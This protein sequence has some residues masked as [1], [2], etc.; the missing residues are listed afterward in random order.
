MPGSSDVELIG[1]G[2]PSRL[3]ARGGRRGGRRGRRRDE[4]LH[5]GRST[6]RSQR[7]AEH[8]HARAPQRV[9]GLP[10]GVFA[11][12]VG[13]LLL[14]LFRF[15]RPRGSIGTLALDPN[16]ALN[17]EARAARAEHA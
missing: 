16:L 8:L 1:V 17:L 5:A 3:G 6:Y 9:F 13:G 2:S 11:L 14:R 15:V 7:R 12:G 4:H 10:V